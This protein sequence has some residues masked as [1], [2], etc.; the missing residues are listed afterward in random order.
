MSLGQRYQLILA[1]MKNYMTTQTYTASTVASQQ[2]YH[3]PSDV[4]GVDDVVITVNSRLY[5]LE[6]IYGQ[7]GWNYLNA[8]PFQATTFPSFIF[9]RRDDFG[10]WPIPQGAYTITFNYFSRDRN[11][12]I[13]DYTA[14]TVAVTGNSVTVTGTGTTFTAA[15]VGRWFEITDATNTGKGYWYRV[16]AFTSTTVITLESVFEGA[17]GSSLTY[18][19][20]QTPEIPEE[21]HVI[22]VD[23]VTADFYSGFKND[24][25]T[26]QRFENKFWTGDRNNI[27]RD[28]G[29]E[30]IA[31]GLIG[32]INRYSSR[33]DRRL[34]HKGARPL[35]ADKIWAQTLT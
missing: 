15:M 5:P 8:I 9:A 2:Y 17:T 30:N 3:Y 33:D 21:G 29:D 11:L 34:I 6:P 26:A 16:S 27:Q 25:E 14:G 24:Q 20:G 19:I 4:V 32:L 10:I 31:G 12:T 7:H 23:G 22:L 13:A 28:T 35:V 18:R 1:R